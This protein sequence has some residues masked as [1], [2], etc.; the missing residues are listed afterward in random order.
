METQT[1]VAR[2][3]ESVTTDL[4]ASTLNFR[5]EGAREAI[6]RTRLALLASTIASLTIFIAEYNSAFSWYRRF[7]M[8]ESFPN[9]PV[10][11]EAFKKVL[12][13]YVESRVINISLLGI[14]VA[15]SDLAILGSLALFMASLWLFFSI[16]RENHTIGSILVDTQNESPSIREWVFYGIAPFLV[17][18][19]VT[20]Y[21]AAISELSRSDKA[22]SLKDQKDLPPEKAMKLAE[23][24]VRY[25][26]VVLYLLPS[27][28]IVG[29]ILIDILTLFTLR[30]VFTYPHRP[31]TFGELSRN[32]VVRAGGME[33]IAVMFLIPTA[34]L[35]LRIIGFDK[36][37]GS[38]MRKYLAIA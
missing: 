4:K 14:H 17:F 21:D 13:Q 18:T 24:L 19:T 33:V 26:L 15:V 35:C 10:T 12:E 16:R 20:R 11:I 5:I 31:L 28:M 7:P 32:L 2:A 22:S 3:L 29:V 25:A 23:K 34:Y 1:G 37:T 38:L 36:A 27:L 9:N 6:K 30:A 8:R